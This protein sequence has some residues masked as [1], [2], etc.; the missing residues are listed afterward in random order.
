MNSKNSIYRVTA[1]QPSSK[2]RGRLAGGDFAIQVK[3]TQSGKDFTFVLKG[4]HLEVLPGPEVKNS[5]GSGNVSDDWYDAL[6]EAERLDVMRA[7][8]AH[9]RQPSR[10][11]DGMK[12]AAIGVVINPDPQAPRRY[13][14][15]LYV[16][17]N[18]HLNTDENSKGCAEQGMVKAASNSLTQFMYHK[19]GETLSDIPFIKEL[20]VM[21]GRAPNPL[22]SDD[23]GVPGI[24]PCGQCTDLLARAMIPGS[25]VYVLPVTK[26]RES[27]VINTTAQKFSEV[28]ADEIWKTTIDTFNLHRAT[29]FTDDRPEKEIQHQ[30]V[31]AM[32]AHL[33]NYVSPEPTDA[34]LTQMVL[35]KKNHRQSIP[36]LD[37]ATKADG[38]PDP[39]AMNAY[40]WN[41][42][43]CTL[44]DRL[45]AQKVKLEPR[46]IQQ[47][48]NDKVKYVRC[49]VI[50]LDDG[51]Y[52]TGYDSRTGSDKAFVNAEFTALG[53]A[54]PMLGTQGVKR[55]WT[56]ECNP[57]A[58]EHGMLIGSTKD[59]LER[60]YKRHSKIPGQKIEVCNIPINNQKLSLD[61]LAQIVQNNTFDFDAVFPGLF[62]G[63]GITGGPPKGVSSTWQNLLKFSPGDGYRGV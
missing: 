20:Y 44:H 45:V 13:R 16:G 24:C 53:A 12:T 42:I 59:G 61:S 50:Q 22:I 58:V 26:G 4:S 39:Q 35:N 54:A 32:V 57:K 51:S 5:N 34:V 8:A 6:T 23:R 38:A 3:G 49:V 47:W 30:G 7:V 29:I 1:L 33:A 14:H 19:R 60:I 55:I 36:E 28:Q 43:S 63:N 21:G 31:D 37:V 40:M 46:A 25:N 56:M 9:Y 48:L 17:I 62:A 11:P 52:Y 2:E 18:N 41:E 27:Q 15:L 10:D